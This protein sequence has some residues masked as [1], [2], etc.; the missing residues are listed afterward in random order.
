M[1]ADRELEIREEARF[2]LWALRCCAAA[3]SRGEAFI[4]ELSRGFELAD[5]T[6]TSRE[7]RRFAE[8]LCHCADGRVTW[9]EPRCACLSLG[10]LFILQALA[11]AGERLGE[12]ATAPAPWWNGV[13]DSRAASQVD[14]LARCWLVS[15]QRAGIRFPR[16][17]ELVVSLVALGPLVVEPEADLMH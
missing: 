5:V 4:S 15:L 2:A 16:P 9:H 3:R 7:F 11:T 10:E 13:M 1:Q 12:H 14:D 17:A 8:L 6:E